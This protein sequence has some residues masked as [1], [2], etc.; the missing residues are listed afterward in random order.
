MRETAAKGFVAFVGVF[1]AVA[2][3]SLLVGAAPGGAGQSAEDAPEVAD[4]EN[5]QYDLGQYDIDE[6]PGQATIQLDSAEQNKTVL[7]HA[8]RGVQQRDFQP[9]ANALVR[10]GHDVRVLSEGPALSIS[11][12]GVQVPRQPQPRRDEEVTVTGELSDVHG[13]L[14]V[15]VEKYNDEELDALSEFVADD[16]RIAVLTE[17]GDA[18]DPDDGATTLQSTLGVFSRPGYVYNLDENDLNY[19]RI[20]AEPRD[21]GGLTEGVDRAVF[22]TATPVG[23][24]PGTA[25]LA[26]I[27]NS[28]V[29]TTRAE[30]DA[31]VLVRNGDAVLAGDTDFM[32]PTNA[33]RADNDALIGNLGDFLVA[34]ERT[35]DDGGQ[36]GS[37]DGDLEA[38]LTSGFLTIGVD[39]E[40]QARES[41]RNRLEFTE[42][43]L[44]ITATVDGN[45]W[46]STAI[47]TSST[48]GSSSPVQLTAPEG[49]SGRIDTANE[50][51]TVEGT[52]VLE[53]AGEPLEFDISATTGQSGSLTGSA[54]L[55]PEGG[56]ATV[57]DNTFTIPAT[58]GP[59]DDALG[60][61]T[62]AGQNW[63][64]LEFDLTLAPETTAGSSSSAS[65]SASGSA[66]EG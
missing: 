4:I 38:A 16:G 56:T 14:V 61:P 40:Q 5:E 24:G 54:D 11:I 28:K 34:G 44:E 47:E 31:A 55:G 26:P 52:L 53:T 36:S 12:A 39:S 1:A 42:E 29:S 66:G 6:T 59:I 49:L 9:L 37:P 43:T 63:L 46:E 10:S 21:S 18:F 65:G 15:G 30:T 20:F 25:L 32:S 33:L 50:T 41:T 3:V 2:V 23:T 17:P 45:Q 64:E 35:V 57:V 22:D 48:G 58:E 62:E 60:L 19:Q 51:L 27:G 7:I 8:G 13:V